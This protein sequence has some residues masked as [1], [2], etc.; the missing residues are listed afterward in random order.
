MA[1]VCINSS[2]A[3]L[4]FITRLVEKFQPHVELYI[5]RIVKKEKK[6]NILYTYV[7]QTTGILKR[8]KFTFYT[9]VIVQLEFGNVDDSLIELCPCVRFNYEL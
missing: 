9:N 2:T 4:I 7:L 6:K 3:Y 1:R 8:K 5:T